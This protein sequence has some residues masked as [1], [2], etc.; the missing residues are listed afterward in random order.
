MRYWIFQN[1]QVLGPHETDD[2]S[3]LPYFSAESLVCPE[4]RKGTS[5]GDWQRAGLVPELSLSLVKASQLSVTSRPGDSPRVIAGLPPEPTLRD[6]AALGS[7]QEKVSFLENALS[8]LQG[9][10]RM[11]DTELSTLHIQFE[12]RGVQASDLKKKL[13]SLEAKLAEMGEAFKENI[14]KAVEEERGTATSVEN[15][16][17]TIEGLSTDLAKLQGEL[18]EIEKPVG[19]IER[20]KE[21]IQQIGKPAGEIEKLKEELHNIEK[22]VGEIEKLKEELHE[23]EKKVEAAAAAPAPGPSAQAQ[24]A[25]T[26]GFEPIIGSPPAGAPPAEPVPGF[27]SP[28]FVAPSPDQG[29]AGFVGG[30]PDAAAKPA[31]IPPVADASPPAKPKK[32]KLLIFAVVGVALAT[33]SAYFLGVIPTGKKAA[34]PEPVQEAPPPAPPPPAEPPPEVVEAQRKILA[35]EILRAWPLPSGKTVAMELEG[36]AAVPAPPG[37]SAQAAGAQDPAASA[38]LTPWMVEKTKDGVYQANFYPAKDSPLGAEVLAFEITL[39]TKAVKG[40]NKPAENIL[41]GKPAKEPP[42]KP[43]K[44]AIKPKK[45]A[46]ADAEALFGVDPESAKPADLSEVDELFGAPADGAPA[47]ASARP[48][49]KASARPPGRRRSAAQPAAEAGSEPSLDDLLAPEPRKADPKAAPAP[50]R[51]A[52]TSKKASHSHHSQEGTVPQGGTP[53]PHAPTAQESEADDAK[54]LDDLLGQ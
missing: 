39:E 34:P 22:P 40:L 41:A 28:P 46:D 21:E 42:P 30:V 17:K 47:E 35:L 32:T 13:D 24:P 14:Q 3:Q 37:P 31:V 18:R 44:T 2:I 9:E 53:A 29:V 54:L 5:M 43:K 11:K 52:G 6:L 12:E 36:G 15:Q 8:L 25:A 33:V 50:P 48:K 1:N 23:I 4:G 10:L 19:E 20:I 38:G 27:A 45:T 16:R 51:P 49:P 26:P 7:L